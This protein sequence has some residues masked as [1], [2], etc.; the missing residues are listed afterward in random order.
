MVG[1]VVGW[2]IGGPAGVMLFQTQMAE[3]ALGLSLGATPGIM[4]GLVL[5]S[6]DKFWKRKFVHFGKC[7]DSRRQKR[8]RGKR[9]GDFEQRVED[10]RV[11]L[12]RTGSS[13]VLV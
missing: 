9:L 11:N 3:V 4:K 6:T 1:G 7:I 8:A 13:F 10:H 2:L 5:L 12:E